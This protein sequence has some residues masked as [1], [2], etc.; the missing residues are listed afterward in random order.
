MAGPNVVDDVVVA[1]RSV[2]KKKVV[3][4]SADDTLWIVKE[5]M[6]LAH[7]RHLPV[8]H[9][10]DLVGVVSQRDLMRASLSNVMGISAE[11]Q[12][13]FLEGV[14]IAE[15]MS[16]PPRTVAPA[17]S[18]QDAARAMAEHKIGCLPVVE[19]KEIVGIVTETDLLHY[20]AS[21]PERG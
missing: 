10:G 18:V 9:K 19:G 13:I 6:D 14:K 11:E 12:K 7:V 17:Q 15:V 21:L 2:M 8:V 20:F 4:I 5:I 16:T 1:V 3:R